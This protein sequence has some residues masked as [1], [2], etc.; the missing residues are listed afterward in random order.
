[1]CWSADGAWHEF[2]R[3][4]MHPCLGSRVQPAWLLL[5]RLQLLARRRLPTPPCGQQTEPV[6]NL[7]A[8]CALLTC[9]VLKAWLVPLIPHSTST[10]PHTL[11]RFM[12]AAELACAWEAA[13]EAQDYAA[14]LSGGLSW[15]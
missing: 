11:L 1:M 5:R 10:G 3:L 12:S 13:K 8:L 7:V 15:L 2:E 14:S 4:H 9:T 6:S